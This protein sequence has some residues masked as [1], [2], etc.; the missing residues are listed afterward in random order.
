MPSAL[1]SLVQ[2]GIE[3]T[4]TVVASSY[5]T[6]LKSAM[7]QWSIIQKAMVH[8]GTVCGAQPT[9]SDIMPIAEKLETV[10]ARCYS[11]RLTRTEPVQERRSTYL[12]SVEAL[13][14]LE[15]RYVLCLRKSVV[16]SSHTS[17]TP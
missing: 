14:E 16:S 1:L 13:Y 7:H 6:P 17:Q 12:R 11:S 5:E 2:D 15:K 4:A 10:M 8:L 9:A 3:T